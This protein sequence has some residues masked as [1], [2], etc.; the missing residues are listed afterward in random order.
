MYLELGVLQLFTCRRA[1]NSA[2]VI[3]ALFRSPFHMLRC[4]LHNPFLGELATSVPSPETEAV[5]SYAY[6]YSTKLINVL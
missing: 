2:P 5:S 6:R 3:A 1:P 4:L